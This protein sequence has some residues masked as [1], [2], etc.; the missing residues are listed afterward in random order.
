AGL[1]VIEATSFVHPRAVPQLAD[2]D[3]LFPSIDRRPGVRYPVLVPPRRGL[4]RA[5]AARAAEIA[6]VIGAPD[7]FNRAN[8]NRTTEQALADAAGVVAAPPGRS[9]RVRGVAVGAFRG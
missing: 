3:A 6:V 5:V 9:G 2:A 8:L 7:S 1:R 4:E